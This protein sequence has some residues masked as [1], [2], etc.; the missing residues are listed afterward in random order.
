MDNS[1]LVFCKVEDIVIEE[2]EETI[3][4]SEVKECDYCCGTGYVEFDDV[5]YD[6]EYC[7]IYNDSHDDSD[8]DYIPEESDESDE[9][10]ESEE[11]D[12]GAACN[13]KICFCGSV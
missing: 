10:D 7:D 13:N 5:E 4:M 6:C 9:S 3:E 11:S 1:Q 8:P 12:C 2:Q